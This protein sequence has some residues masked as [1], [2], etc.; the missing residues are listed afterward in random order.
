MGTTNGTKPILILGGTGKTGRRVAERARA[1]GAAGAH[2]VPR[3]RPRRF[4]WDD[5]RHLGAGGGRGRCGVPDVLPRPRGAGRRGGDAGVRGARA[6]ARRAPAGPALGARRAGGGA[7]GGGGPGDR[8]RRDGP[9]LDVVHA[10]L[11]RGLHARARP[12][13]R[14]PAAQRRRPDP[15]PGCRRHRRRGRRRVHRRPPRR[16]PLRADRAALADLRRG[17]AEIGAARGPRPPLRARLAG[18]ARRELA[19]HDVSP[20]RSSCCSRTCSARSSTAATPTPPG[21][22]SWRSDG[23]RA[24]SRTTRAR[25]RRRASGTGGAR[26]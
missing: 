4:D 16:S 17:W 18:G 6:G 25:P 23:H 3:R 15:V 13:G 12:G 24:T 5:P 14:D 10:E 8:C 2:R 9:A 26:S 20:R 21:A 22:S 1:R 19:A 11:Q 7:R